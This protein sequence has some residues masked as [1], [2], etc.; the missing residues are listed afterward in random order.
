MSETADGADPQQGDAERASQ[1]AILFPDG[2]P[3]VAISGIRVMRSTVAPLSRGVDDEGLHW[4]ITGSSSSST[5]PPLVLLGDLTIRTR[6]ISAG[7]TVVAF[8][9]F[10]DP[11]RTVSGDEVGEAVRVLG[12]WA[13]HVLYDIAAMALRGALG[14]LGYDPG[15]VP[16]T[17]PPAEYAD[18]D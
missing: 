1:Q 14:G 12:P 6:E 7:A 15:I 2:A 17:T 4:R 18:G 10:R 16:A 9:D 5:L 8:I 13:A 3:D 11:E